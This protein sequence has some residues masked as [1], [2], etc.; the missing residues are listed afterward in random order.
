MMNILQK[1]K[2]HTLR[3]TRYLWGDIQHLTGANKIFYHK[4]RGSRIIVYHG[5]CNDDPL[6]FNTLFLTQKRFEAHLK[7]YR[8]Y[9]N[10]ISLDDHY[11]GYFSTEK[12]NICL[13]FD[14]G[15]ANNHHYV[16]PLLEQPAVTDQ[17]RLLLNEKC[18][19]KTSIINTFFPTA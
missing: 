14:D 11:A 16:L 7:F 2:Q 6:K 3:K 18:I 9:F 15:F 19:I 12:F 5:V 13:T 17:K 1:I 10:P 4:A 8:E